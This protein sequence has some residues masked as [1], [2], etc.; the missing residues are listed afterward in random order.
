[1][2]NS[3]VH[4]FGEE[5]KSL[6]VTDCFATYLSKGDNTDLTD[7][8]FEDL[9]CQLM[10]TEHYDLTKIPKDDAFRYDDY[11]KEWKMTWVGLPLGER[12]AHVQ[13]LF[14]YGLG[15]V[16]C[17]YDKYSYS[18]CRGAWQE[19]SHTWHCQVCRECN[20]W[21]EWHCEKCKKCT[22]GI[23]IPC[24]G[25]GGVHESWKYTQDDK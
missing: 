25:C 20:D 4:L 7:E 17:N 21:R 13:A 1:M 18:F 8:G 23:S 15:V 10:G 5:G 11:L 9:Y 19:E 14:R 3:I 12:R 16:N 24:G 2:L 6:R 22:Y